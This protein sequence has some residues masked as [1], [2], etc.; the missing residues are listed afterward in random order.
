MSAMASQITSITSVYS[1]YYTGADQRK[2]TSK[3][4]VN[5]LCEGNSPVTGECLAPRASSAE[6][7]SIWRHHLIAKV[8]LMAQISLAG[9]QNVTGIP[10]GKWWNIL[11]FNLCLV[12]PDVVVPFMTAW[13]YPG[14]S[15]LILTIGMLVHKSQTWPY[16]WQKTVN[17][18]PANSKTRVYL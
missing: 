4:R 10:T 6:I 14:N 3:L 15:K 5:G 7:V 1:S 13:K 11:I 8:Y 16:G 18:D 9:D 17:T 2:K 12:P